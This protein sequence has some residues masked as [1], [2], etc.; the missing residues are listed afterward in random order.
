MKYFGIAALA[1]AM[2]VGASASTFTAL[3]GVFANSATPQGTF[4]TPGS[5]VVASGSV[6]CGVQ[7]LPAFST[8]VSEA[9]ILQTDYT[10]GLQGS[11]NG[12]QTV[13]SGSLISTDTLSSSGVGGSTV[14]ADSF[15]NLYPGFVPAYYWVDSSTATNTAPFTVSYSTTVTSGQVQGVSGQVYEL[16]TYNS[17]VPEPGSMMLLGGGLIAVSLISRKKFARK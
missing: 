4:F 7:S 14:Y 8:F 3:C 10:G 13:Y 9:V 12:I 15:S 17:A 11:A 1:L 6:T 2:S 5:G 16:I